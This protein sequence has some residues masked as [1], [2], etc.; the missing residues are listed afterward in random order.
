MK[1]CL[2]IIGAGQEQIRAYEI[3]KEMELFVIG[4]DANPNAPAL[5]Y[6]DVSLICST[7][8]VLGT[9]N[10]I[11]KIQNQYAIKGVMTI[12]NDAATTV[13][14]VA[15][16]LDLPT[17]PVQSAEFATNKMLM[18]EKFVEH[19]VPTPSYK[20]IKNRLDFLKEVENGIFP[21]IIKPSDG[22][23]SRGVLY[24]DKTVD[25]DWAFNYAMDHSENKILLLEKFIIG[26]QLS[27]E[28]LFINGKYKAVAF[29][30]RNYSNLND[31]KPF[32]IEDGGIIPTYHNGEILQKVSNCIEKAALSLGI[33]RGPVKADIVL[34]GKNPMIIEIAARLS[35]NYLASHHLRWSLGVDIVKAVIKYSIGQN[36]DPEELAPKFKKY[37]S[38]RYFFPAEGEIKNI[39]GVRKVNSLTH[40]K[41]LDI[42]RKIGDYQPNIE[43]N[44]DR[45]G[46]VRCIGNTME[47]TTKFVEDAV[48]MI[49]FDI[50]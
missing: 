23:G 44:I 16:L 2:I 35:G 8:D 47:E 10:E 17:I 25:F 46:I 9:I 22:R 11:K 20:I 30:D 48:R 18:K 5:D 31:T 6:A 7:R 1:K 37:L 32:I 3:A 15:N 38:A 42:Y 49:K 29:A 12:G 14:A 50:G 39:I 43:S 19:S 45:A 4:T 41:K 40:V 28:G 21:L 34:D 24:L 33:N 36:V 26:D 13:A 27:V